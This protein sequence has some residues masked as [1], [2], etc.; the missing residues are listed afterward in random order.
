MRRAGARC[1]LCWNWDVAIGGAPVWPSEIRCNTET[2][3]TRQ[4]DR[5]C[6]ALSR[7]NLP[8]DQPCDV[9]S[10]IQHECVR[11]QP[12]EPQRDR[13]HSR[14]EAHVVVDPVGWT[15]VA[16]QPWNMVA[17]PDSHTRREVEVPG[18]RIGL[19]L[20]NRRSPVNRNAAQNEAQ[21]HRHIQP[22][23]PA[24]QEMM[25]PG[26]EHAGLFRWHTRGDRFGHGVV[27]RLI[28]ATLLP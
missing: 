17:Y 10:A 26:H 21:K 8:S 27:A 7:T 2:S 15:A 22:V 9:H 5:S 4:T 14:P 16:M 18:N 6:E 13:Q 25:P 28:P 24:D 12:M 1:T 23:T 3:S 11:A 20:I 19:V